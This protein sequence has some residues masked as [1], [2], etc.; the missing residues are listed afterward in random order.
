M[1]THARV[2]VLLYPPAN[3]SSTAQRSREAL[4]HGTCAEL[5]VPH[6][7]GISAGSRGGS[8]LEATLGPQ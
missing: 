8:V 2:C 7:T 3:S 5:S 4:R 1:N 6:T